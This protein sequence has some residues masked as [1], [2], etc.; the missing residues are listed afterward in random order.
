MNNKIKLFLLLTFAFCILPFHNSWGGT[1]PGTNYLTPGTNIGDGNQHCVPFDPATHKP[2]GQMGGLTNDNQ[3]CTFDNSVNAGLPSWNKLVY[4]GLSINKVTIPYKLF[5]DLTN[6]G[7]LTDTFIDP[8]FNISD[9]N[10]DNLNECNVPQSQKGSGHYSRLQMDGDDNDESNVFF[11]ASDYLRPFLAIPQTYNN[12]KTAIL[13]SCFK[14]SIETS[15]QFVN[16]RTM[17]AYNS[18][19]KDRARISRYYPRNFGT[20]D[21]PGCDPLVSSINFKIRYIGGTSNVPLTNGR[22]AIN[23]SGSSGSYQIYTSSSNPSALCVLT[24]K[25]AVTGKDLKEIYCPSGTTP[26]N[27]KTEIKNSEISLNASGI[28]IPVSKNFE[29]LNAPTGIYEYTFKCS[30]TEYGKKS[31][32]ATTTRETIKVFVGNIPATPAISSFTVKKVD[33][34]EFPKDKDGVPV[35][36]QTDSFNLCWNTSTEDPS[37]TITSFKDLAQVGVTKIQPSA[38]NPNILTA[39]ITKTLPPTDLPI[40]LWNYELEVKNSKWSDKGLG[41]AI[42]SLALNVVPIKPTVE[43]FEILDRFGNATTSVLIS[44]PI[45]LNWKV[46][47]TKNIRI[48]GNNFNDS[49]AAGVNSTIIEGHSNTI[50]PNESDL[51]SPYTYAMTIDDLFYTNQP[52]TNSISLIRRQPG[53]PNIS[54]FE[55]DTPSVT[56]KEAGGSGYVALTWIANNAKLINIQ[57]TGLPFNTSAYPSVGII[58]ISIDDLSVAPEGLEYTITACPTIAPNINCST[59]KTTL[60]VYSSDA[61]GANIYADDAVIRAGNSTTL[62]WDVAPNDKIKSYS[63]ISSSGDI[64]LTESAETGLKLSGERIIAP[65]AKTTYTLNVQSFDPKLMPDFSTSVTVGTTD[66][67][68]PVVEFSADK[69]EI[70]KGDAVVLTWSAQ[71]AQ[72]VS[73][74]NNIGSVAKQGSITVY[75]EFATLYVLTAKSTQPGVI[76]DSEKT[77]RIKIITPGFEGLKKAEEF[78]NPT[79][80][81]TQYGLT[82]EA[83]DAAKLGILDLRVNGLKGPI[84]VKSPANIT[85]SWNLDKYC[86]ATGSWLSVKTKAGTDN[87][88]LK[89][90]G[91]YTYSLYCPGAGSD[92]V[93]VTV[94]GGQGGLLDNLL[95]KNGNEGDGE[96]LMPVAEVAVSTD[97]IVF[98]TDARVIK[99]QEVELFIRADKDINGDGKVSHDQNGEWGALLSNGGGCLY[100]TKLTKDLQFDG[101]VQSPQSPQDCNASLGKFTFNDEP[102]TYQYGI[103][104]LVQNDGKFSNIA[105]ITVTVDGPPAP[106]SA[107]DMDFRIN[108]KTDAEQTLGTPANYYLT[109]DIANADTCLATGSWNGFKPL[110]GIQNFL[111]SS[112]SDPVYTLTC[113]GPLGITAKT[114][115]L[116]IVESPICHFTALPPTI[117]KQ[118]AF[119]TESELSWKCDYTDEC[120]LSPNTTNIAIK[121]YGSLRVSPDQTTNY[122]LTC[123]NSN[124]SKSFEAKVEVVQ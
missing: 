111:K 76:P 79:D 109:W 8:A 47:N 78:A 90:N 75:P 46:L 104:K 117:S 13:R 38:Q 108:G 34:T 25:D 68:S 4:I 98:S 21:F 58:K 14:G 7:G 51:A 57:G 3:L 85:L 16:D 80:L 65:A 94:T 89:K 27:C 88:T 11:I 23:P 122:I 60:K 52:T 102:G 64:N 56:K 5:T 115:A 33:G 70:N 87:I 30:G 82:K 93:E 112:Q 120:S 15:T 73:I 121:T 19:H 101:G 10:S 17:C 2:S 114:I 100:N 113:E 48:D 95:G 9:W 32:Q 63:V 110:K 53:T 43:K 69:T 91:K 62:R 84:T 1:I 50:S 20:L 31:T 44:E 66:K 106:N 71:D 119:V 72:E 81:K 103:F 77:V 36:N 42:K 29:Q 118:S 39:C 99:G 18:K 61:F 37:I 26:A 35:I 59:S 105:Y 49:F 74:N 96:G 45:K 24:G 86:L 12:I 92:S 55:F 83:E 6:S 67:N 54:K 40:G 107:P 124:I 41:S 28:G 22:I 97:K 123:T 116:K